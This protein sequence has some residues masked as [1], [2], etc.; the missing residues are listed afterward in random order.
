MLGL[1]NG[2]S[3]ETETDLKDFNS[4]RVLFRRINEKMIDGHLAN[5]LYR[6]C[7]QRLVAVGC[8]CGNTHRVLAEEDVLWKINLSKEECSK[9][10][11]FKIP[12]DLILIIES[13]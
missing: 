10:R 5:H 3:K 12:K 11:K 4:D 13:E 1:F 9:L 7:N 2:I 6:N 8:N